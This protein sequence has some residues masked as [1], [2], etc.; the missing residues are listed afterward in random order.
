MCLA[1][2]WYLLSGRSRSGSAE[3]ACSQSSSGRGVAGRGAGWSVEEGSAAW[4]VLDNCL[5]RGHSVDALAL[6]VLGAR[7]LALRAA[8]R[9][10]GG[11]GV[12][13]LSPWSA[14]RSGPT[15]RFV[16]RGVGRH[17]RVWGLSLCHF[18]ARSEADQR[19]GLLCELL[20]GRSDAARSNG[21]WDVVRRGPR[22]KLAGSGQSVAVKHVRFFRR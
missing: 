16:L 5:V 20:A 12:L 6:R 15:R 13:A 19:A 7:Q 21:C 11:W 10:E 2:H 3:L 22:A 17:E 8:G 4:P 18:E 14:L 9:Q 1:M